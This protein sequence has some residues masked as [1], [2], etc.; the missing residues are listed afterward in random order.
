MS[1]KSIDTWKRILITS[2]GTGA[3][4][5]INFIF[6]LILVRVL[7]TEEYAVYK[8]GNLILNISMSFFFIISPISLSYF[9][10]KSN[11]KEEKKQYLYQ[12][13]FSLLIVS[14]LG[15]LIIYLC[16]E[17]ISN[18]YSNPLL[19]EY[20]IYFALI[21]FLET[22]SSFYTYYMVAENKNKKLAY[23]TF[24]FS[25]L[26]VI[27]L[28]LSLIFKDAK[29]QAFM[30]F[31][32]ISIIIKFIVIMYETHNDFKNL[33]FKFSAK[34]FKQQII[35]SIPIMLMGIIT[36][37]NNNIDK[38]L[39]STLYNPETYAIYVNGAFEIPLI[40]IISTSIITVMLPDIA[41]K[42]NKQDKKNLD[43]IILNFRNIIIVCLII[44]IPFIF[45]IL[46][47]SKEIVIILFSQKYIECLNLFQ[48]YLFMLFFKAMNLSVLIT[49]ADKQVK[50]IKS[51]IVMIISN[52]ILVYLIRNTLGFDYMTLAPLIA[53]AIMNILMLLDIKKIYKQDKI[54]N[55]LPI[56]TIL[57]LLTICIVE[58][59]I[60]WNIKSFVHCDEI[61]K[62]VILGPITYIVM[63]LTCILSDENS[64]KIIKMFKNKIIKKEE[65]KDGT[66]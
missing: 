65:A 17:I 34:L 22:G 28:L 24:Q 16:R 61:L 21:I 55:L 9:L 53:T 56:L 41:Q 23:R 15:S 30:V 11:T 10:A 31:Y 13:I 49:A 12:T 32:I 36:A 4:Q 14:F 20:M 58:A 18:S 7:G 47:F 46:V 1:N 64:R 57:K 33:K 54:T 5:I 66:I 60:I 29:F 50:L 63:L 27:A 59:I 40:S 2:L 25:I 35:F 37:I 62:T 52:I 19:N 45:S 43:S 48:I 44:I 39:V 6:G 38:N 26:R 3:S 42:L 8:Q 51:G